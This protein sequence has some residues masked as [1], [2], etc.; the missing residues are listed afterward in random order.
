MA[1]KMLGNQRQVLFR[2][3]HPQSL[4][5]FLVNGVLELISEK[6]LSVGDRLPPIKAMAEQFDVATPTMREAVQ[7]LAVLGVAEIRHGSGTYLKSVS[8]PAVVANLGLSADPKS[9]IDILD[10]R[11]ML[12][13]GLAERAAERITPE[14]SEKMEAAVKAATASI[15]EDPA[16]HEANMD[17][18]CLVAE[19]AGN[20]IL[21][22]TVRSYTQIYS[23][24]QMSVLKLHG[25]EDRVQDQQEHLEI[26]SAIIS[27]H[28]D[29]ARSLMKKHL[30]RVI[31]QTRRQLEKRGIAP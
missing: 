14:L 8:V 2:N 23:A 27:G 29:E 13:P 18:H 22:E 7:H 24:E 20:R 31:T 26:C 16:L 9:M 10:A 12:E 4:T 15:G 3:K 25:I 1:V 19:A 28:P 17:F 30:E 11:L 21:S 5:Q 6:K